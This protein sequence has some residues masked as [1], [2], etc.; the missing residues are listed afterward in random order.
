MLKLKIFAI[1]A[2]S[3]LSV[4][5][6]AP[7]IFIANTP[8]I[9]PLF[10]QNM[11][12]AP[13]YIASIPGNILNSLKTASSNMAR[14]SSSTNSSLIVR[15]PT[16]AKTKNTQAATNTGKSD[17][18][19]TSKPVANNR[20]SESGSKQPTTAPIATDSIMPER[21]AVTEQ[22]AV[23]SFDKLASV[24]PPPNAAF[25]PVASGVSTFLDTSMNQI[26]LKIDE[27]TE[28]TTE[29]YQMPNGEMMDVFVIK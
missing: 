13:A 18:Y 9:S 7:Q 5:L 21:V 4:K 16:V 17:P 28:Y 6:L 26:I 15:Q 20:P 11:K 2:V 23:S 12:N 10:V 14:K 25:I 3:F 24:T 22:E 19:V 29:R 27:G 8:R 1:I